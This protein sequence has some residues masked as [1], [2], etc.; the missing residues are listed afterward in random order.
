MLWSAII[1]GL[2]LWPVL[3]S[4]LGLLFHPPP[5]GTRFWREPRDRLL[6][7]MFAVVFSGGLRRH[8]ARCHRSRRLPAN[9]VASAAARMGDR[10]GRPPARE[11]S[12]TAIYSRT[13]LDSRCLRR[14]F[15][16]S[17]RG[18]DRGDGSRRSVPPFVGA[19]SGGGRAD[20]SA[21]EELARRNP[22]SRRS[23]LPA[24]RGATDLAIL[25]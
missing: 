17:R 22:D 24:R 9:Q 1:A 15:S 10:A 8:G 16:S 19:L 20:Q 13:T 2:M 3:N 21:S 12:A 18:G 23:P 7:S 4:L 6:R 25:R 5:P 14:S 11:K